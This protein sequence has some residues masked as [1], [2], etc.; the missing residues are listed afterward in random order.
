MQ[1]FRNTQDQLTKKTKLSIKYFGPYPIIEKIGKIACRLGLPNGCILHLV[2]HVSQLKKQI[3]NKYT[4]QT[5]LPKINEEG[6]T[7]VIPELS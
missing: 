5:Q 2:F 7:I 6:I 3:K 4:P 1:T